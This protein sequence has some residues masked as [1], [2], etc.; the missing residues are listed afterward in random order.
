LSFPSQQNRTSQP[1]SAVP[2]Q[3]QDHDLEALA[4]ETAAVVAATAG[5]RKQLQAL[6]RGWLLAWQGLFGSV[7]SQQ[8]G[9]QFAVFMQRVQRDL[10]HLRYD[11]TPVLLDYIERAQRLG[12]KQGFVEA[13]AKPVKMPV[14]RIPQLSLDV[15]QAV[16]K[17]QQRITTASTLAG[18][19]QDG[20]F[21]A[22][23]QS[24]APA[25]QA[26]NEIERT[27]RTVTNTA[28]NDGITQVAD[29]LDMRRVWLA[30]RDACLVC[31]ALAGHVVSAG[32]EFSRDATFGAKPLE[33]TP[34]GAG[35]VGPPRH[36]NCRCRCSP[37]AGDEHDPLGLPVALRR[38]AERSIL[39][40]YA[41]LSESERARANAADRLLRKVGMAKGSRSPSGWPVPQS[42]KE[43]AERAV[44]KGTFTTGPVPVPGPKK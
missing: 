5:L 40:G 21:T 27:A 24:T 30:E 44:R 9:P 28:L 19:A 3:I 14:K 34:I 29:R 23:T 16:A 1:S 10:T 26:A 11:P 35:L 6:T 12:V 2:Q 33:W 18:T 15:S 39:N 36:P 41:R 8:S 7:H 38:E 4:L 32:H 37:W 31:L 17:A 43:R 42:V 25:Q 20:S 22:V 13:G